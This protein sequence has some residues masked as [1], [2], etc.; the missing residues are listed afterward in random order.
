MDIIEVNITKNVSSSDKGGNR[1]L[2]PKL[3]SNHTKSHV[4]PL[5]ING[6]AK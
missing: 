5:R 3:Y 2:Q 4:T 6:F 1:R